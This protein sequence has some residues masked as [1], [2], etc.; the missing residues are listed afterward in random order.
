MLK[1]RLI[2]TCII[3]SA[4]LL[5]SCHKKSIVNQNAPFRVGMTVGYPPFNWIQNSNENS[6]VK[7]DGSIEY[8]GGYDVAIAKKIA[9]GL[10]RQL[11]IVK[12]DWDGLVPALQSNKIDAIIAGMS[13]TEERNKVITFTSSYYNSELVMVVLKDS[14][15][16]NATSIQDFSGAKVTGQLNTFHYKALDQ[17]LGAI[18]QPPLDSSSSMRVSLQSKI[19]DAYISDLPEGYSAAL[20]NSNFKLLELKDDFKVS[21]NDS[22]IAI[23]LRKNDSDLKKINNILEKISKKKQKDLMRDAIKR[24][25]ALDNP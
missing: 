6:G 10:G 25:P 20:T 4:F 13:P 2:V 7:V 9:D 17:L 3:I 16:E 1:K 5:V 18:K 19:I 22:S 24:Q 11:V 14:K 12:T 23:G 15:Y 21:K 8:V